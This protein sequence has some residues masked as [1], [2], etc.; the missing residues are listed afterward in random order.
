MRRYV[1][2]ALLLGLSVLAALGVGCASGADGLSLLPTLAPTE[3][4]S[5]PSGETLPTS[6]EVS[7]HQA[8][9]RA[10]YE[11]DLAA[12]AGGTRY[13]LDVDISSSPYTITAQQRVRYVNATGDTLNEL[14][15]RLYPNHLAGQTVMLV[16]EVSVGGAS[17]EPVLSQGDS[18]LEV[19]LPEPLPPGAPAEIEMVYGLAVPPDEVLGLY[20]RLGDVAGVLSLPSFFPILSVY[21]AGQ[22]DWWRESLSLQGDPVYSESALFDVRLTVPADM[23]VATVGQVLERADNGDGTADYHIV[24][25]PVRDFAIYMSADFEVISGTLDG[26][27]VNVYSLPGDEEADDFALATTSQV[28][29]VFNREFGEYPFAELD[30]VETATLAGG[31]EYPG[32]YV[33][34]QDIW[35]YS[36]AYFESVIIHE[37][38][39]QWWYSVVGNDQVDEPWLD[40]ALANYSTALYYTM[41]HDSETATAA[42]EAHIDQRYEAYVRG[43]GDGIVGGPTRDYTRASH[44]PLVYAKGTLFFHALRKEMGDEAFFHGLQTYYRR[45]KYDVG[46]P[47]GLLSVME[48]A[49]GRTLGEFFQRGV[50]S[51]EGAGPWD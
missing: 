11:G 48:E 37:T 2:T 49:H 8:A 33:A 19:S 44:Y 9:M 42:I 1:C 6:D 4:P 40:E 27:T 12:F 30:V 46:T 3:A 15:F 34:A 10:G 28:M 23:V 13:W 36:D 47:E 5:S 29:E 38:A 51:A 18:V 35:N 14:V 41:V 17:V 21:D 31:I 32:V 22:G 7:A 25:G 24:T 20:G 43:Y 26:V 39:H 50:F 16:S 45:F